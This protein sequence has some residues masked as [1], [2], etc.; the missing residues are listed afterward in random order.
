[1][2]RKAELTIAVNGDVNGKLT[3]EFTGS[4]Y[5]N[6]QRLINKPY[7]E[8]LKLLK[9]EYDL[10]NIDF[11][12]FKLLQNKDI[13]PVTSE[14]MQLSILK[15]AP[16]TD[17]LLYLIPNAFNKSRS[18]PEVRN[19]SLPVYIN[20]GYTDEDEIVYHLPD[21]YS[22]T[23]RLPDQDLKSAFGSYTCSIRLE[24][25][26]LTYKRKMVLNDGTFPAEQ[27]ENLTQFFSAISSFDNSKVI[28]KAN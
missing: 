15:Y 5:D 28:L 20:R 12:E 26:K 9:K 13:H 22:I 10:D 4:Q 16:K 25:N 14:S 17:N 3:T 2:N 8:Q 11:S 19:R 21:G 18:I 7:D 27:Y 24:G 1:M 6:Y 23:A